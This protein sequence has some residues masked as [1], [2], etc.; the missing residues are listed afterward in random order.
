MLT[1]RAV[2]RC[3]VCGEGLAGPPIGFLFPYQERREILL[4]EI[5]LSGRTGL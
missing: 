4:C 2:S 1:R 3:M 5:H